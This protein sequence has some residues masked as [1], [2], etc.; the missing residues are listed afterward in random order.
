MQ[1]QPQKRRRRLTP[2]EVRDIIRSARAGEQQKAIAIRLRVT[3]AC[4]CLIVKGKR[5]AALWR[6]TVV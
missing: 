1:P 5:H 4:V 3:E 6:D 2:D